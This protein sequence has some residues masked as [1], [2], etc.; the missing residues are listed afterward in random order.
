MKRVSLAIVL[1][2]LFGPLVAQAK[3][4]VVAT[5]PDVGSLAHEIGKDKIDLVVLG[6]PNDDPH[7]VPARANFV[8]SLRNA[9]VL[10]QS[11]ADLERAWLPP[12]LQKAHNLKIDVEKPGYVDA[13]QGIRLIE[14]VTTVALGPEAHSNGNPHFIIDPINASA[15]ARH[16]AKSFAAVDPV[17]A[18][19]YDVNY[20]KFDAVI[21]AKVRGWRAILQD[22]QDKHLA[23]YHDSWAYFAHRFDVKIDVFLEPKPGSAPTPAHLTEAIQKMKEYH[24]K[25]ILVEPYQ[26]RRLAEKIARSTD[27]TVVDFS[28]F[29]GGIPDTDSYVSLIDQLV[30]K[31]ASAVK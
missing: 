16:I 26:D 6:K 30:K 23:A 11:G 10:I 3:L 27:A 29:P 7:F 1:S 8:P 9:D 5:F 15:V 12:L 17:N 13:S 21:N 31:F 2:L 18:A 4:N 25:A 28:V 22:S 19:F 24:I 20:R 14:T